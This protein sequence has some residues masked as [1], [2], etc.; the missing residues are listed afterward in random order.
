MLNGTGTPCSLEAR[1][2]TWLRSERALCSRGGSLPAAAV[3]ARAGVDV[4]AAR[5]VAAEQRG[6]HSGGGSKCWLA[7]GQAAGLYFY[8]GMGP[9]ETPGNRVASSSRS[10]PAAS[11]LRL[12]PLEL[13]RP[14]SHSGRRFSP[15]GP[16]EAGAAAASVAVHAGALALAAALAR[17]LGLLQEGWRRREG[18]GG[19][20][21][22]R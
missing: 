4:L 17:S 21:K 2:R 3:G 8:S 9:H 1:A 5:A 16:S 6:I 14:R 7:Y 11:A 12:S 18:R 10:W 15:V 20:I 13:L 22:A 19:W